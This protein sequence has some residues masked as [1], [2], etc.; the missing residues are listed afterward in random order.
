[1]L[2]FCYKNDDLLFATQQI[3]RFVD[4]LIERKR[5]E[6]K[7]EN[8]VNCGSDNT[9]RFGN[10]ILF[11]LKTK[12]KLKLHIDLMINFKKT[13]ITTHLAFVSTKQSTGNEYR[14]VILDEIIRGKARKYAEHN[15]QRQSLSNFPFNCVQ[16]SGNH[17]T[18]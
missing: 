3:Q 8:Q 5:Y 14:N 11:D 12:I 13:L 18:L 1:M 9:K 6:C 15:I 4:P 7:Y 17:F 16:Q 10:F 2:K